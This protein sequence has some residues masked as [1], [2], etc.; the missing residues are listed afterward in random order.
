M[1]RS[2]YNSLGRRFA[3]DRFDVSRR[4]LL[5][6]ALAA[7]AML[8][9]PSCAGVRRARKPGDDLSLPRIVVV[10]GGFSGLACASELCSAGC[11]VTVLEARGRVGGR[12]LTFRDFLEARTVEGGGELI[13]SNHPHWAAYAKRFNLGMRPVSEYEDLS[14]PILLEGRR[15][16]DAEAKALWEEM[17]K[18]F[19]S[20]TAD[21]APVIE[22]T[23]WETPNA[24]AIDARNTEQWLLAQ[25]LS[26]LCLR[27]LRAELA[28]N[29][30]NATTNQSYLGNLTQVKGG[31]LDKYW[32]E[33]E[34]F[35]CA[36]GNDAL[37]TALAGSLPDHCLHLR[38]PV[39]RIEYAADGVRVHTAEA[40]IDCD[41]VVLAVPPSVW[42]GIRFSPD[43]PAPLTP[44]M[45]QN[46]KY[47]AQLKTRF[48]A[49]SKAAPTCLSDTDVSMT[50]EGTDAQ[51]DVGGVCL[52]SF[53]G[54][55]AAANCRAHASGDLAGHYARTLETIYPGFSRQVSTARF[56]DWPS[57]PNTR[58]GYSFPAP[59]QVTTVGPLLH[60]GLPGLTFAGEHCCYKFVGYME[61]AL[62]SG[63][64]AARRIIAATPPPRR[65]LPQGTASAFTQPVGA[66]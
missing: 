47:L 66:G 21:A 53:S 14:S 42:P 16:D 41:H 59:G 36:S 13:G 25:S 32:T 27:A 20:L 35:R 60:K 3:P 52:T 48:W 46:V 8:T 10:G 65:A 5:K 62:T 49:D 19:M 26:P 15:L 43:L 51:S 38:T 58:A 1:T 11:R 29:N 33:S 9:L 40:S 44:Q 45:G 39:T 57:D 61:G 37:A 23:P 55:P 54:G 64:E 30:G 63:V 12:V 34:V 2:L 31:G 6:T 24:A 22:D 28:A 56:M 4:D 50:W 17:D 7:A 18:A